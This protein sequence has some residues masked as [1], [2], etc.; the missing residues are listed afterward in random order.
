VQRHFSSREI[1]ALY[2]G[3]RAD[4]LRCLERWNLV[5]PA[6]HEAEE[7]YFAFSELSVIRQASADLDRGAPLRGVLRRL[8]AARDGQLALDF[9]SDRAAAELVVLTRYANHGRAPAT[10]TSF[11]TLG[12]AG[13]EAPLGGPEGPPASDQGTGSGEWR[14]AGEDFDRAVALDDQDPT[15]Q[16]EAAR[17]YRNALE[18]D[19][20]CVPALVNLANIHH[21]RGNLVEAEALYDRAIAIDPDVAEA[22][23]NLGNLNYD[24]ERLERACDCYERALLVNAAFADAQFYLAVTLERLGRPDDA[25]PHW[26]AYRNL[27]PNGEWATLAREFCD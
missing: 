16:E 17:L 26:R 20:R 8:Q 1:L 4:R 10:A 2:P 3:L 11:M 14:S 19:P 18:A 23:F 27:A 15:Q 7:S 13:L 25:R 5:R 24:L 22:H 9:E 12:S 21:A 6:F